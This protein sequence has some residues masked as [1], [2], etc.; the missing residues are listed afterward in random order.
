MLSWINTVNS[1]RIL[2]WVHNQ[3]HDI[4]QEY[5]PRLPYPSSHPLIR[6]SKVTPQAVKRR[7]VLQCAFSYGDNEH[8]KVDIA[9]PHCVGHTC[10]H[11]LQRDLFCTSWDALKHF[12]TPY[13]PKP[14]SWSSYRKGFDMIRAR[15]FTM[16]QYSVSKQLFGLWHN[17]QRAAQ[18][19]ET[20]H[21]DQ[22]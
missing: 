19:V 20:K 14:N 9:C 22:Y 1:A 15:F 10:W 11:V 7:H 18:W 4:V 8:H 3:N 12:P 5:T 13:A 16:V 6:L 2:I 17:W 21:F